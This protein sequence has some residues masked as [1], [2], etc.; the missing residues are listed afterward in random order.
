MMCALRGVLKR[1]WRL[2]QISAEDY[3][4]AADLGSVKGET[5]PAG[6]EIPSGQLAALMQACGRD[7]SAAGARDAA[8]IGLMYSAGLRRAE[9]VTLDLADYRLDSKQLVVRGKGRKERIAHI[10]EGAQAALNDW[11]KV[12][13][14]AAGPLS[15][16]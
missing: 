8:I 10:I 16:P 12:R 15:G 7:R 6:R 2:G 4:R 5:V 11:L 14:T 3:R 1:S 13:G 9:V